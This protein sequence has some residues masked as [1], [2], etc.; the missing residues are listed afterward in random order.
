LIQDFLEEIFEDIALNRAI[1]EGE[2]T[3]SVTREEVFKLFQ[4]TP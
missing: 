3:E 1:E 4:N 2:F